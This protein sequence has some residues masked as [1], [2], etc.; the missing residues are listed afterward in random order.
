VLRDVTNV[1]LA[2]IRMTN[3]HAP[4]CT[5]EGDVVVVQGT[6]ATD[7][8]SFSSRDVWLHHVELFDGGDGLFD[9]RG[10][11]RLTVSWSH[12][13]THEK[14][15]LL[16]MESAGD[17]EGREMEIAFHHN[18][19]DRISRRGPALTFGR[20]HYFNNYQFQWYEFGASSIVGAQFASENN[21]Y[22]ARPGDACL[23]ACP[24]P[25][26][27]GSSQFLVSKRAVAKDWAGS[28]G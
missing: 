14:G 27:C 17:I 19:F 1:I 26:P 24:D 11:S 4:K 7:P 3:S 16:S 22:E 6:G 5:Q 13:H 8:A 10:G 9:V 23:V 2:D 28:D 15:M 20:V 25:N 21:V 12:F 18:Y